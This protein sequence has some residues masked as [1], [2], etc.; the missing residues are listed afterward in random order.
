M[1]D[2]ITDTGAIPRD[3][4]GYFWA[5]VD[6]GLTAD[7]IM[8]PLDTE[9]RTWETTEYGEIVDDEVVDIVCSTLDADVVYAATDGDVWKAEDGGDNWD[10]VT[11]FAVEVGK[12]ITCL[13]VGWDEDDDPRV[14]V[15]LADMDLPA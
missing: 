7:H 1:D 15:G 2:N 12:T 4:D 5:F 6:D 11:E 13:A 3:I 10:E 8:K 14:F 9:G